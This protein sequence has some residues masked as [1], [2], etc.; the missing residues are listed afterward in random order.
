MTA[1]AGPGAPARPLL[2]WVRFGAALPNLVTAAMFLWV[3]ISPAGWR[4]PLVPAMVL[5][6]VLELLMLFATILFSQLT[7]GRNLS[8]RRRVLSFLGWG[9]FLAIFIIGPSWQFNSAWPAVTLGWLMFSHLLS[10][11]TER[12]L[13][14]YGR[15]MRIGAAALRA[16]WFVA[17][18]LLTA[19]IPLP[20]GG[21]T[22]N[23]GFYGVD[24]GRG[25]SAWGDE[26]HIALATG[27]L[28][29]GVLALARYLFYGLVPGQTPEARA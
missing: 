28:Y 23:I 3:W 22:H 13:S 21:V 16:I 1:T 19:V 25:G 11:W 5:I 4:E 6:V 12:G 20:H 2:A 14:H 18:V 15:Q 29:F 24:V 9:A 17:A 10:V 27:V 8:G 7:L 26:P